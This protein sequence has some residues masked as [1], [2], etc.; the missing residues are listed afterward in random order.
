[1]LQIGGRSSRV[2]IIDQINRLR[3]LIELDIYEKDRSNIRSI[4]TFIMDTVHKNKLESDLLSVTR[5]DNQICYFLDK[6]DNEIISSCF[7]DYIKAYLEED[8]SPGIIN[9]RLRLLGQNFFYDYVERAERILVNNRTPNLISE[10]NIMRI[11][12][13]KYENDYYQLYLV[14]LDKYRNINIPMLEYLKN[15]YATSSICNVT[16][17][18]ANGNR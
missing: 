3:D 13:E 7:L 1:M 17:N 10:I 15:R 16:V 11:K 5:N 6:L 12:A 14:A 4:Y 8:S 18:F 9:D 2:W